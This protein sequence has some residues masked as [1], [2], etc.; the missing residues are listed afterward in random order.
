MSKGWQCRT[1]YNVNPFVGV[2]MHDTMGPIVAPP[3]YG[4]AWLP[5]F[6]IDV[7]QGFWLGSFLSKR[8]E[9]AVISEGVLFLGRGSDA[10]FIVPHI[11]YL[12]SWYNLFTTLF[13]SSIALF[14]STSVSVACKNILWGNQDCDV[15]ATPFGA[16]PVSLNLSCSDPFSF[17]TDIVIV[18]GSVYVGMSWDDIKAAAIDFA[19]NLA[20][21]GASWVGGKVAGWLWKKI[22]GASKL[23]GAA[24][25]LARSMDYT[26]G[27]KAA[28]EMTDDDVARYATDRAGKT[29]VEKAY[30]SNLKKVLNNYDKALEELENKY[31]KQWD[32]AMSGYAEAGAAKA[33]ALIKEAEGAGFSGDAVKKL[34]QDSVLDM[35]LR[36]MDEAIAKIATK[37]ARKEIAKKLLKKAA[38]KFIYKNLIRYG[39]V[40]G[41]GTS[42]GLLSFEG[43]GWTDHFHATLRW[44]EKYSKIDLIG[45]PDEEWDL[46]YVDINDDDYWFGDDE[47]VQDDEAVT[48]WF[49]DEQTVEAT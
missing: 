5:H 9:D 7:V 17:F 6:Q 45:D 32:K 1:Y 14:G 38:T 19:I 24:T 34:V 2:S 18:W 39:N 10:G 29:G 35:G 47:S 12:P 46:A 21:E 48:Y 4:P 23:K 15:A 42:G 16:A 27:V 37:T 22:K 49:D 13:G 36:N 3:F 33:R 31:G 26:K 41:E 44:E 8:S 30:S 25:K 11:S 40:L 20:M 43:I 28:L